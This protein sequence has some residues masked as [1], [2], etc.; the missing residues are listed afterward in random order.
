MKICCDGPSECK[1][2]GRE[3]AL[4]CVPVLLPLLCLLLQRAYGII[5]LGEEHT[6]DSREMMVIENSIKTVQLA[7]CDR[8]MTLRGAPANSTES[9]Y[10]SN[11]AL[12]KVYTD[13]KT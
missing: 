5:E 2:S 8:I 4:V 13:C 1:T 12:R 9:I 3:H 11:H 7:V 10:F 6:L